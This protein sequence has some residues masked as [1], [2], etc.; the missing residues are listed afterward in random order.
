VE[1]SW[2]VSGEGSPVVRIWKLEGARREPLEAGPLPLEGARTVRL[3][4]P[5]EQFDLEATNG[6]E[7]VVKSIGLLMVQPPRIAEFGAEPGEI[8]P[9]AAATL[10]W[11]GSGASR[12]A[13]GDQA[14]DPR[15]GRLEVR[16][17]A[18]TDYTLTLQNDHGQT[19]RTV[20]VRVAAAPA[21]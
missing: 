18:D 13:I 4:E 11:R 8:A 21:P 10:V 2:K 15:A 9:G 20:T 5:L 1:L 17:A 19:S 3:T 12:A 6:G 14:V 7:P 16:P